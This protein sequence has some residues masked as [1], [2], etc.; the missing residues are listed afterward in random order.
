LKHLVGPGT[1]AW[2]DADQTSVDTSI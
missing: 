1:K 2:S